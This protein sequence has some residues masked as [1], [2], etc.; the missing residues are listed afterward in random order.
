MS[1]QQ[2]YDFQSQSQYFQPKP[3]SNY[4][5]IIIG[6]FSVFLIFLIL[7]FLIIHKSNT[8]SVQNSSLMTSSPTSSSLA[9]AT[10]TTTAPTTA[11][12]AAPVVPVPPPPPPPP[13]I[14]C[15]GEWR[16]C[17]HSLHGYGHCQKQYYITTY[18]QGGGSSCETFDGDTEDDY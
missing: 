10:A 4:V 2:S 8:S 1:S 16:E 7:A 18:S 3:Q 5:S 6:G 13:K 9:S 15:V 17:D 12:A 14:N 11:P